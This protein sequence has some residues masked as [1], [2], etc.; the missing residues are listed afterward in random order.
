[1]RALTAVGS[2]LERRAPVRSTGSRM[3]ERFFGYF[4][5]AKRK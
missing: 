4:L 1:M 2:A 3:A 5:F